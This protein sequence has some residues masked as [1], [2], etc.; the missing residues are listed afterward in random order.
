MSNFAP[1][2]HSP[3][4]PVNV[5]NTHELD[6]HLRTLERYREDH[7][8]S[9][10]TRPD[11]DGLALETISFVQIIKALTLT[12]DENVIINLAVEACDCVCGV[13]YNSSTDIGELRRIIED[14]TNFA[15][16][17]DRRW[18]IAKWYRSWYGYDSEAIAAYRHKLAAR[19]P[20]NR[21]V[22]DLSN[23]VTDLT[24]DGSTSLGHQESDSHARPA[25]I[26]ACWASAQTRVVNI[27]GSL[28]VQRTVRTTVTDDGHGRRIERS[29]ASTVTFSPF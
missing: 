22:V 17:Y 24:S 29:E 13:L 15:R 23:S 27:S 8:Q 20:P 3:T 5:V 12:E 10:S 25:N 26:D 1:Q 9:G 7:R 18:G 28:S 16:W 4:P 2:P 21:Q 14:L 11:L 19:R 6:Q